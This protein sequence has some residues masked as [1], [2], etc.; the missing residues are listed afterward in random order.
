MPGPLA[1]FRIIDLTAVVAGPIAT[2]CSPIR[3]PT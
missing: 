1:G 2:R 3:A